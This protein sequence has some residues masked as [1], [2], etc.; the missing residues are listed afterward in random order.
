MGINEQVKILETVHQRL[1]HHYIKKAT[2]ELLDCLCN[3]TLNDDILDQMESILKNVVKDLQ[4]LEQEN[5]N[6][7][8]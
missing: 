1:R 3:N 7:P 4:N 6:A 2:R 5:V 8:T